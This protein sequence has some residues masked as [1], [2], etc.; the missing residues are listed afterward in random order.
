MV[1]SAAPMLCVFQADKVL[2][3]TVL[4]LQKC[5][6]NTVKDAIPLPDQDE[7]QETV[8]QVKY[9]SKLDMTN[10]YKQVHVI[11]EHIKQTAFRTIYGTIYGTMMQQGDCNAPSMFHQL[12]THLF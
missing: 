1:D 10:M 6:N 8:A 3:H 5:N 2:I 9:D 7:I 4:N 12:M 11:P